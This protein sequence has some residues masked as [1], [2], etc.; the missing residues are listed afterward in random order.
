MNEKLNTYPLWIVEEKRKNQIL[1]KYKNN[2][3]FNIKIMT[4]NEVKKNYYFDYDKKAIYYLMKEYSY[5]YDIAKMYLSHLYEVND[6]VDNEKV[7]KI[8]SLKQELNN[9]NLLIKKPLFK[10]YLKNNKILIYD[11]D[12]LN[13]LE[14]R[15]LKEIEKITEVYYYQEQKQE[16]SHEEIIVCDTKEEEV[17]YVAEQITKLI[18]E[19]INVKNIKIYASSEYEDDIE[20]IF[21]WFHIKTSLSNS[22]LYASAIGQDFL[23]NINTSK[24]NALKIIQEKY[25]LEKSKN[26]EIYNQII[27]ILNNYTWCDSNTYLEQF[28]IEDFKNTKIKKAINTNV[29]SIINSLDTVTDNDYVFILGFNQGEIPLTYKDEEYF[30]DKEKKL[31]NL[32]T[33]DELNKRNTT[34]WLNQIKHTKN[35]IITMKKNSDAGEC[36][37]SNLNDELNL[38]QVEATEDYTHSNLYNKLEFSKKLD[39]LVKYNEL[40]DNIVLLYNHYKNINYHSYNNNYHQIDKKR[41]RN[42]LNH[43]LTLSYSS[44]NTY[45]QCAFRYYL[46]NILK[47]NIYDTTFYTIIGNLFHHVLSL[48]YTKEINIKEEYEKYIKSVDYPF[49]A[50]ELYFLSSLEK[51]LE[52]IID[53]INEQNK[54]NKL[55]NIYTEEKI[56]VSKQFEDMNIIFKGFVDKIMTNDE[57]DKM[58]II[59]YKTGSPNLNLNHIIYG[60]DLQ[61]PVYIYLASKK[62]PSA[63]IIGFYLQKILNS[64]IVKDGKHEF[65][66]LKKEKLKLQ[67]YT[68]SDL[69]LLRIFDPNYENSNMIKGMRITSKGLSTKKILDDI[70]IDT[71]KDIT[72]KKIEESIEE[73]SNANFSINPKRIGMDNLGCKYCNYKDICF[74]TEKNIINLKEYKNMEFLGGE[75][76]DTQETS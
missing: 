59:D 43:Q 63:R 16:Y 7:K 65:K 3:L 14:K 68:N 62:L 6:E 33:T 75:E 26:L 66:E 41:I 30:N 29:V 36:Y 17:S 61:L 60:L 13:K 37:I 12:N 47:I 10:D 20:R 52:F 54:E 44:M 9:L 64:E 58:A 70:K 40:E 27:T 21:S 48:Y 38:K 34:I 67:G 56:E 46:S 71:L 57:K 74:M 19:N 35:L 4:L 28:L 51:E 15:M 42:Y 2:K 55:T 32:D 8:L 45:Y 31:L 5:Q 49:N 24:E 53:T 11:I 25:S 69:S 72:N 22:S 18:K 73:I 1:E 50:R 76:D 23:K 39:T